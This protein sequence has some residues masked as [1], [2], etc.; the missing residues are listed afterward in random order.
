MIKI[1]QLKDM[2]K[3]GN[4]DEI[5]SAVKVWDNTASEIEI[6]EDGTIC[7]NGVDLTNAEHE[8]WLEFCEGIGT[9]RNMK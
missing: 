4:H 9:E 6:R 5:K 3:N 7:V 2:I 8:S 1:D